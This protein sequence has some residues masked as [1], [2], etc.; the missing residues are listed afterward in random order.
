MSSLRITKLISMNVLLLI[1][2]LF[3]IPGLASN[4]D[5]L[6][7]KINDS[8]ESQSTMSEIVSAGKNLFS[9]ITAQQIVSYPYFIPVFT[10]NGIDHMNINLI[11]LNLTGLKAGDE[12]GIFDGIYCVGAAVIS[13]KNMTDNYISITASANDTIANEPDGYIDGHTITLKLYRDGIV[14]E[15]YFQAV[16]NTSDVFVRNG[17]MFAFVDVSQSTGQPSENKEKTI[18]LFPNPFDDQLTINM[19]FPEKTTI[20][21]R[22]YNQNGV[23]TRMLYTGEVIGEINVIWDGKDDYQVEVPSGTYYC[24]INRNTSKII[25]KRSN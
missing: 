13:D 12:I 3:C 16:N 18:K 11:S 17:S 7:H 25:F 8:G 6:Q 23:L 14:Y 15:L 10:G 24:R 21:I 9:G 19:T 22:I 20:E 5:R 1:S 2:I 4:V